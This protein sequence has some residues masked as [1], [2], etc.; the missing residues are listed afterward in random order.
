MLDERG[1]R[2][3][4]AVKQAEVNIEINRLETDLEVAQ[5]RVDAINLMLLNAR[6]T[7][8]AY[9]NLLALIDNAYP[10]IVRVST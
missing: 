10:Q 9:D 8:A 3:E 5:S 6:T 4:L 7:L 2:N 1:I